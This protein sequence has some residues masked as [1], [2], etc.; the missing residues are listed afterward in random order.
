M[1]VEDLLYSFGGFQGTWIRFRFAV[2]DLGRHSPKFTFACEK[3][4]DPSLLEM[5]MKMVPLSTYVMIVRRFS[6][7]GVGYSH[8]LVNQA[9]AGSMRSMLMDWDL[10]I[11]QI[12]TQL[13]SGKPFTLQ[14]LWYYIQSPLSAFQLVA[15][16]SSDV[17]SRKLR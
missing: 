11:A 8:G 1:L 14:A 6:E 15:K 17:S 5:V 9:L 16:I 10:M 2:D 13:R 3:D 7:I 4:L 12:E